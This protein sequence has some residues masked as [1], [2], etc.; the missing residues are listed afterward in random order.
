[1]IAR[2]LSAIAAALALVFAGGCI[3]WDGKIGGVVPVASLEK[4]INAAAGAPVGSILVAADQAQVARQPK[5]DAFPL[6]GVTTNS[7]DTKGTEVFPPIRT[8]RTPIYGPVTNQA[9]LQAAQPAP[10]VITPAAMQQIAALWMQYEGKPPPV[11]IT[12]P[13]PSPLDS[14]DVLRLLEDGAASND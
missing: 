7:Y 13:V 4:P 14:N 5:A 11:T 1:M 3:T 10:L 12:P 8:V 6:L 9:V 2:P